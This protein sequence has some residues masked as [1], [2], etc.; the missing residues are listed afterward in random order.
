MILEVIESA[1][2]IPIIAYDLIRNRGLLMWLD[3]L[4]LSGDKSIALKLLQVISTLWN[5]LEIHLQKKRSSLDKT[6]DEEAVAQLEKELDKLEEEEKKAPEVNSFCRKPVWNMLPT[7]EQVIAPWIVYELVQLMIHLWGTIDESEVDSNCYEIYVKVLRS[8]ASH[9]HES[10]R[11]IKSN[12]GAL[13]FVTPCRILNPCLLKDL[14]HVSSRFV[15]NLP[16]LR[17][18]LEAALAGTC[19]DVRG[20]PVELTDRWIHR[21]DFMRKLIGGSEKEEWPTIR[22]DLHLILSL[23]ECGV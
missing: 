22:R 17:D 1:L 8:V 19:K 23:A 14:I 4:L 16:D 6:D 12:L 3:G 21:H 9:V 18:H 7:Q 10:K 20:D 2:R 5:T 15:S 11:L 13:H